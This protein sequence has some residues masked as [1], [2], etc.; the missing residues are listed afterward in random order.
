MVVKI[1]IVEHA[2]S[3]SSKMRSTLLR[4]RKVGEIRRHTSIAPSSAMVI[5]STASP[6]LPI[7]RRR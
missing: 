4:A 5:A 6:A 7:D 3:S 1:A 2:S